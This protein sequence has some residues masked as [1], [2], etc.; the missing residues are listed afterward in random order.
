MHDLS[1]VPNNPRFSAATA[2]A[3]RTGGLSGH[4]RPVAAAASGKPVTGA[5]YAKPREFRIAA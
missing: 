4:L 2:E 1:R 3:R 5:D